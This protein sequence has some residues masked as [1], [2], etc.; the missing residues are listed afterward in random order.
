MLKRRDEL[1]KIYIPILLVFTLLFTQLGACSSEK[2]NDLYAQ[3]NLFCDIVG[4]EYANYKKSDKSANA[5]FALITG[6]DDQVGKK[7]SNDQVKQTYKMLR[8]IGGDN[9]YELLR[10]DVRSRTGKD[11][12]CEAYKALTQLNIETK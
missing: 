11:F 8:D 10:H 1:T 7:L 2:G 4:E 5:K 6:I 9:P 3:Y 12:N